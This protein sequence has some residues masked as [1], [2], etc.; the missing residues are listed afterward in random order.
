MDETDLAQSPFSVG[1]VY[2]ADSGATNP[3][4]AAEFLKEHRQQMQQRQPDID[5]TLSKM[6]MSTETMSKLLDDTTA[7][8]KASRSG[9]MNMPMLAMA[10]GMLSNNGNFG[11]QIGAGLQSMIPAVYKDRANDDQ[12]NVQIAQ[13]GMRK[14][15]LE[16]APLEAKLA[17]MKALQV[18]DQT[19][20]RAIEQALI[21]A[22]A[23]GNEANSPKLIQKTVQDAMSE[24]RKQVDLM[25]KEMFAT[26]E[27]REAEIK[28]RFGENI[29]IAVESGIQLPPEMLKRLG[30]EMG[31]GPPGVAP[32]KPGM[33]QRKSYFDQPGPEALKAAQE[34]GMP[35]P[36]TGYIYESIG[37]GDRPK[38]L[39]EQTKNFQ[40][41]T[42]D[43]DDASSQQRTL[44]AQYDQ[45]ERLLNKN[46]SIVGPRKGLIPNKWAPNLTEDAQTLN[47]LFNAAQLH[48]VP[49]GQGAVSNLERELF[50][51]ASPNMSINADA[52]KNLIAIR[53]EV[54]AR[55]KDRRDF[56][57]EYFNTYKTTDGMVSAW[58]KYINAPAGSAFKRD[59]DGSVAPNKRM[60]WREFF[61]GQ[62]AGNRADG[63]YIK[64]GDEFDG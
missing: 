57:T 13:L 4:L 37:P 38:M 46:P 29:K 34:A 63:G 52:N 8:L 14:S 31:A 5:N 62:S 40:R 60:S 25:S 53:K 20:M 16:Q 2:P 45:M 27:E 41:E 54:I 35:G 51:S 12:M 30:V 42:K 23:K 56:F 64:L 1:S 49:K 59:D 44:L 39:T 50:A 43:F 24:A 15:M 11:N 19:A 7:A 17:Y 55:D 48:D 18:G 61:K 21:R 22:Q 47:S 26:A 3:A 6:Q 32:T 28:R 10:A 36:P 9:Q 58:D 33:T